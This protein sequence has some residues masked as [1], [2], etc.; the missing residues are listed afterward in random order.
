VAKLT[1]YVQIHWIASGF[2]EAAKA[3]WQTICQTKNPT[4]LYGTSMD[5]LC[6]A[7]RHAQAIWTSQDEIINDCEAF[8]VFGVAA[9][10]YTRYRQAE[11]GEAI[12]DGL[13]GCT[14]R[15]RG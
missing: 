13:M 10:G 11:R 5:S 12:S 1:K 15:Q 6:F 4:S 2:F 14:T 3:Q 9:A 7:E 8:S